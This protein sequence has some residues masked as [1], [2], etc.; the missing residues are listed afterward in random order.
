MNELKHE[1]NGNKMTL[2]LEGRI[3]SQNAQA[4]EA[5]INDTLGEEKYGVVVLNCKN[6]E[7]ISSAGLRIVLK[8]MKKQ[9]VEIVDTSM[10]IYEIFEMTGFTQLVKVKKAYKEFDITGCKVIGEGAKGIVYRYNDDTVI[11]V[12]KRTD[13]L[14]LIERERNLAR[15]A[16]VLGI[17]T[18]ISYDVVKVG[19]NYA[20]VF[21]LLESDSMS[22][23]INQNRDKIPEYAKEF[24]TLLKQIHSTVVTDISDMERGMSKIYGWYDR[25][26]GFLDSETEN[27]I[28]NLVE[29]IN[30]P[31]TLIHGDYHT[32][33]IMIQ[34]GET[35]LI[36]MDTLAYGNPI[37]E[38]ANIDFSF[39]NDF[40][41]ENCVKFLGISKSD[42]KSFYDEFLKDYF[43][44]KN[45]EEFE[46][47]LNKIK[48]AS[49]F[50]SANHFIRRNADKK[51]INKIIDNITH[52]AKVVDDMNI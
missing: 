38:L 2:F 23:L 33:N 13:V 22:N 20:S 7:Y 26:K 6:L 16:F 39:D 24:S 4:V 47:V 48:L 43:S 1:V 31:H 40:E 32:N 50:R 41:D 25:F 30:E 45:K 29:N 52:L 51:I 19:D 49:S 34:N 5:L 3:D 14:P 46:K 18:A 36:D 9:A 12:Y 10:E 44:D 17:P 21:E 37:M 15:K 28:K 8:L 42:A 35:I 11:K 27:K